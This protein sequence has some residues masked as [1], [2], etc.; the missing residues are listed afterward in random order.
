[1]ARAH[2]LDQEALQFYREGRFGD[3]IPVANEA[4]AIREKALGPEHPD[5]AASL[6]N[7]GLLCLH[8]GR[9]AEAEPFLKRALAIYEKAPPRQ[10]ARR[11]EIARVKSTAASCIQPNA[12]R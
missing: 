3:A 5:V 12:L 4:L 10:R 7:L 8:Q 11:L 2:T 9:Y 1:M 6:S